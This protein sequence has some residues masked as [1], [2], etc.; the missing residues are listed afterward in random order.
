VSTPQSPE[1][2]ARETAGSGP[3][4][5]PAQQEPTELR[6]AEQRAQQ[7]PPVAEPSPF[8]PLIQ[9]LQDTAGLDRV[10]RGLGFVADRLLGSTGTRDALRGTWFG[11]ALHPMLTDLP[12]GAWMCTTLLDVF[13]GPRARPAAQG[14][15]AFGLVAA[16]PTAV[17]GLAEWQ[18]TEGS[19]RRVG[20][21]HANANTVA[22]GLYGGSLLARRRGR[23]GLGVMLA[24]GGGAVALVSGYLGGHLSIVEKVGTGDRAW[25]EARRR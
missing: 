23:H 8:V 15:L 18:A 14:L 11:H 20:V 19:A 1:Q 24:L 21:A 3:A 10:A 17:T 5:Q 16:V 6:A 12:L 2:L 25:Y 4:G 7:Q 9:R 13:G 22:L